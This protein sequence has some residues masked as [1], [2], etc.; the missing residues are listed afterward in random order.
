MLPGLVTVQKARLMHPRRNFRYASEVDVDFVRKSVRSIGRLAIKIPS[1][2]DKCITVLLQLISTKITYVTQEAVVVIKD[3]FRRYPNQYE[4]IIGTLCENLDVLEEPEA[5]SAMIW[6]VGQYA[7][8]I[9]NSDELLEDWVFTFLEEPTEVR[10]NLCMQRDAFPADGPLRFTL[11]VQLALLTATVKLFI[12]RPVAGQELLPRVLKMATEEADNPDLRDRVRLLAATALILT[13]ILIQSTP[14]LQGFMYWRMISTDPAAAK[15]IVLSEKPPIST[16]TDRMDRGMLDQLLLHTGTLS[17][18]YHKSPQTFI[19][20]AKA[21]YL[22][23]SPAMNAGT[24]RHLQS[25][26][27]F[28][29]RP[30]PPPSTSAPPTRPAPPPQGNGASLTAPPLPQRTSSSTSFMDDDDPEQDERPQQG[31]DGRRPAPVVASD[32]P[33]GA[34]G[35]F[36]QGEQEYQA[37]APR[38]RGG[39]RDDLLF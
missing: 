17:S 21:R 3:I 34:L 16:E 10:Y 32:D 19:R 23:D 2:A 5:K 26:S 29:A 14:P 13:A 22:P 4:A 8:R 20:T 12:K 18:I 31:G 30:T 36:D 25:A 35:A 11:Q 7:E 37:D 39:G 6:I 24:R 15:E 9:E 28:A 33:Y 38:P 1:A 27:G